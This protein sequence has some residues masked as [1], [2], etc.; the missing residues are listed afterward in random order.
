MTETKLRRRITKIDFWS[1]DIKSMES[2]GTNGKKYSGRLI[3]L[4][5]DKEFASIISNKEVRK[6]CFTS[7]TLP[8]TEIVDNHETLQGFRMVIALKEIDEKP[9]FGQKLFITERLSL[10]SYLNTDKSAGIT[11]EHGAYMLVEEANDE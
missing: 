9:V 8:L 5:N 11:G 10:I 1:G 3:G 2:R 7:G 6:K 4:I